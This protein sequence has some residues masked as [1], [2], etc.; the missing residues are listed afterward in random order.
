MD[1]PSP[2]NGM[3]QSHISATSLEK[4]QF[5]KTYIEMKYSKQKREES[6][7]KI[8]W[9][10]LNRRMDE[11]GLSAVEKQMIKEEILHKEAEGLREKRKEISVFD[12]E[13][14]TIIGRGAF[15]EVRIVRHK[16]TNKVLAMKKI[17]KTEMIRKNQV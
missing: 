11:M 14:I 3:D 16:E 12:F 10:E 17:N 15:G 7:K 13:P 6:E 4:A 1:K 5:A 9:D 8:E 2:K